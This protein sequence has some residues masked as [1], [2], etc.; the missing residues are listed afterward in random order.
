MR[1]REIDSFIA[2]DLLRHRKNLPWKQNASSPGCWE[3]PYLIDDYITRAH[4][5]N[6]RLEE[7]RELA[8]LRDA[9]E[10]EL[11]HLPSTKQRLWLAEYRFLEKLMS[12]RQL[13][14]YAPAFLTLSRIMPKKMVFCRREVV[15]RY[16]KLNSLPKTPYMEKLSRQFVR[17]SVLLFPAEKLVPAADKFIRL[18]V[19]S[20]DQ[21]KKQNRHRVAILLRS[22]QMMSD[23]EICERFQCEEIYFDELALLAE[24]ADH[25]R[26]TIEDIFRVS[27]E[28]INRFWDI[29][30]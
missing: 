18:A 7:S 17:S 30:Y 16:L 22:H 20:A 19:R 29:Q 3:R 14:V 1:D 2:S 27:A 8:T 28:E 24:L 5:E 13:V 12:F 21:S 4:A 26:L 15:H 6:R 23:K 10:C 25:Y 11:A 9:V